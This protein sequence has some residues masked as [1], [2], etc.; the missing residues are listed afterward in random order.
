MLF[1][2]APEAIDQP[3]GGKVGRGADGES[4]GALTLKEVLGADG[5][6]PQ[7]VE[8]WG[9]FIFLIPFEVVGLVML[10]AL[11]GALLEPVRRTTWGFSRNSIK[12]SRARR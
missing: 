11:L 8:W 9:M 2:K 12:R 4:T 1:G 10:L 6:P 7:G 5:N 3:L